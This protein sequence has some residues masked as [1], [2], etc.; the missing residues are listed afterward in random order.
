MTFDLVDGGDQAG[1][2]DQVLQF[3]S[4]NE[5]PPI[6]TASIDQ[7]STHPE[8]LDS[9]GVAWILI[10]QPQLDKVYDLIG[11]LQ[12]RRLPALLTRPGE[13]CPLGSAVQEGVIAAP[14]QS[15]PAAIA[16]VVRTLWSTHDVVRALKTELALLHLQHGGVIDQFDKIDEELRLAAQLQRSFLPKQM[17]ELRDIE[18]NVL[19]R[20]AGYVSGDIYDARQLDDHHVGFFLV[21]AV[22]HGVPAA[23]MTTYIKS[24]MT[25]RQLDAEAAG[26]GR[27]VPPNEA[28][29]RLNRDVTHHQ[30]VSVR[31]ATAVYGI[32]DTRTLEA[33]VA[34]AGHPFP[35]LLQTDGSI[36][37]IEPDGAILGVFP[38]EQYELTSVQ[39]TPGDR[40]IFHSDGFEMAFPEQKRK[41]SAA[42]SVTNNNYV[43]EFRDLAHGPIDQALLRLADKLD[44]QAGSLN[45]DDD[46]TVLVVAVADSASA[47]DSD[48]S[49]GIAEFQ[50]A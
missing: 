41:S 1:T 25:L 50:A 32:I 33:R 35:L 42:R 49:T 20:P 45:Q 48:R 16:A 7:L 8:Q 27:I 28:M 34:R 19:F 38:D 11:L 18:I 13:P 3:W 5:R 36:S 2:V 10:D 17:P 40:L 12:D 44:H 9:C 6:A 4:E 22:G 37:Q 39:L 21:D 15:P 26:D 30:S 31:T 24:A 14:P 43:E 47:T 23:L 29:A 46:L